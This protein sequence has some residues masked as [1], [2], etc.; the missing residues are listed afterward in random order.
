VTDVVLTHLH[1]D[2][3]GGLLVDGVRD[4]LRPDL[5]V[6]WRPPR[7]SSGSRPILP[8]LHCRP[9]PGR[10]SA[11]G[12]AVL[13]RVPQ[14]VAA[15]R[16]GVRVAPGVASVA[17]ARMRVPHRPGARPSTTPDKMPR[18]PRLAFPTIALTR[19]S[20]S[21]SRIF[22][23]LVLLMDLTRRWSIGFAIDYLSRRIRC[24]AL[25]RILEARQ[26]RESN[27]RTFTPDPVTCASHVPWSDL[28]RAELVARRTYHVTSS[29]GTT[30][31]T[32]R[33]L[34]SLRVQHL[35]RCSRGRTCR[36]QTQ[37]INPIFL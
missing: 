16:D 18:Q 8:R 30:M 6:T 7:P 28:L 14:P 22:A 31:I 19:G 4:R 3:I 33:S 25:T 15:V 23:R 21:N 12:Q 5:R 1:M 24:D 37:F 34:R 26:A 11:D 20:F 2:H 10:A 17:P 29:G 36:F 35:T 27:L 13:E 32:C 9:V